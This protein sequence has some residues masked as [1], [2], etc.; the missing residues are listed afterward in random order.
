MEMRIVMLNKKGHYKFSDHE[1]AIT[2]LLMLNME[3]H[4][5]FSD[6]ENANSDVE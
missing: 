3:G 2:N 1:N 6:Y 5:K 4:Y